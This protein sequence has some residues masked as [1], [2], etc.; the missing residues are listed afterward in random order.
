[1]IVV[2]DTYNYTLYHSNE[3]HNTPKTNKTPVTNEISWLQAFL[4]YS[5][6]RQIFF[7]AV[8]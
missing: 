2:S 8:P 1:M 5:G 6:T 4:C 7:R 3:N